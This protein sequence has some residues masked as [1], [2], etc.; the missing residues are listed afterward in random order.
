MA[1]V[2]ALL[3]Q[4]AEG[5]T[6]KQIQSALHLNGDKET[7][8]NQFQEY[9]RSIGFE[10]EQSST[11]SLANRL[12]LQ[13]GYNVKQSFKDAIS[14]KLGFHIESLDFKD[15]G[16]SARII[17][18]FVEKQTRNKIT[19]LFKPEAFGALTRLVAVNAVYFKDD[20]RNKF[21]EK[22]TFKDDFFIDEDRKVSVE[23]M[24]QFADFRYANLTD[25]HAAAVELMYDKSGLSFVIILPNSRTGLP[26]LESSLAN[27]ELKQ[28]TERLYVRT[29]EIIFPKFKIE[30]E[31]K[32]TKVLMEVNR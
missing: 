4:G 27:L 1:S 8:A 22:L 25:L 6:L 15:G 11:L 10:T 29:G 19:D 16:S 3:I 13:Q 31:L 20:W 18:E 7:I 28:I 5:D 32:L 9:Y 23:F 21:D 24:R 26:E 30:L 12:Y 2:L 17:N 14:E